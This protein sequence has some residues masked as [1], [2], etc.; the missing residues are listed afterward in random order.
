MTERG[1]LKK[2]VDDHFAKERELKYLLSPTSS[3]PET[4]G[5]EKYVNTTY[6]KMMKNSELVFAPNK[7]IVRK[8][9]ELTNSFHSQEEKAKILHLWVYTTITYIKE[10]IGGK[11]NYGTAREIF[12]RRYGVCV[13]KAILYIVMARAA[14]LE[15]GYVS[16]GKN[17]AY[18]YTLISG[19]K[20]LVDPTE[21]NGFDVSYQPNYFESDK[22]TNKTILTIKTEGRRIQKKRRLLKCQVGIGLL[23]GTYIAAHPELDAP[24]S[25]FQD[26][27]LK[28][29]QDFERKINTSTKQVKDMN[30]KIILNLEYF[31]KNSSPVQFY[32]TL[33]PLKQEYNKP[34]LKKKTQSPLRKAKPSK[35]PTPQK[36][37]ILKN[38]FQNPEQTQKF[39]WP[40]KY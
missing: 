6:H 17:H 19:E 2:Y 30:K 14:G 25:E 21:Q 12:E 4:K 18:A 7:D 39:L 23:L 13:D 8:S 11:L 20:I 9:L 15:A 24:H 32:K 3:P 31:F 29:K 28:L 35:F 22:L 5:L 16:N 33:F 37:D 1:D 38:Y 36:K 34:L 27:H 26:T 40:V 10:K